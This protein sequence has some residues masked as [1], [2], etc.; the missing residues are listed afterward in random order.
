M[1]QIVVR[2][3]S[4]NDPYVSERMLAAAFGVSMAFALPPRSAKFRTALLAKFARVLFNKMFAA[5]A[6]YS[7]THGLSR[8]YARR[9]TP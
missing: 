7:T 4:I 3:L 6:P 9:I 1:F 2:S 5:G 8:D